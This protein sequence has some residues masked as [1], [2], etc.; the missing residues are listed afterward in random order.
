MTP[1]DRL[2][3]AEGGAR[4]GAAQFRRSS[5]ITGADSRSVK[6]ARRGRL[7]SLAA[8]APLVFRQRCQGA[9]LGVELGVEL[10]QLAV[11]E[12]QAQDEHVGE[13]R[14]RELRRDLRELVG[15]LLERAQEA[16]AK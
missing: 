12:R 6:G 3:A 1:S 11:R 7:R 9:L 8:R 15:A 14:G 16:C 10:V 4:R 2:P 5:G 13:V